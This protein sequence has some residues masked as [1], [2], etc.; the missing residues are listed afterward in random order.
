MI[1]IV[2]ILFAVIVGC[3]RSNPTADPVAEVTEPAP[4][5]QTVPVVES[6]SP[7][8]PIPTKTELTEA[9][10]DEAE[11]L[12]PA[13]MQDDAAT[14]EA[15]GKPDEALVKNFEHAPL[16]DVKARLSLVKAG[17]L[18]A[19][20]KTLETSLAAYEVGMLPR[21]V[22]TQSQFDLALA[23]LDYSKT[24]ASR[25]AALKSW[26]AAT[27]RLETE[28]GAKRDAGVRG[29]DSGSFYAAVAAR[30]KA[31]ERLVREML[32]QRAVKSPDVESPVSTSTQGQAILEL[33]KG[34]G[35]SKTL[36]AIGRPDEAFYATMERASLKEL[37][38]RLTL[39]RAGRLAALSRLVEVQRAMRDSGV[40]GR[41]GSV[42]S[43]EADFAEAQ[44][45]YIRT[46]EI[47]LSA[48]YALVAST[49]ATE[50]EGRLKSEAV[51]R[52]GSAWDLNTAITA[53][54]GAEERLLCEI[55]AQRKLTKK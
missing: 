40:M 7:A 4:V 2:L 30:L 11:D 27:S 25:L 10:I 46:P 37:E 5:N 13:P 12:H 19:L 8:S 42:V 21:N 22:L 34:D 32:A 52:G 18:A 23:E 9:P 47:R 50:N 31:E 41:M 29:G 14:L 44:A 49:S 48:L 3:G 36:E 33:L 39:I 55:V 51:V 26:V 24:P 35:V 16:K 54:L 28:V 17:R 6:G 20:R 15:I 43:A 45:E 38:A 53:R 1:R